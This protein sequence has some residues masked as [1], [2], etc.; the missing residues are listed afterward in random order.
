MANNKWAHSTTGER[1]EVVPET[2]AELQ[3][4]EARRVGGRVACGLRYNAWGMV[5]VTHT[6]LY[7]SMST[8]T[9]HIYENMRMILGWRKIH[10]CSGRI[11]NSRGVVQYWQ[12]GQ[13]KG[14]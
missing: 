13:R 9:L 7:D 10:I 4:G 14:H 5:T 12:T 11:I 8:R 1:S 2:T 6:V 3:F